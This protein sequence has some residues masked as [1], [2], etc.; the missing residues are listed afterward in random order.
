MA[1]VQSISGTRLGSAFIAK[2]LKPDSPVLMPNPTWGNHQA[3]L[4]DAGLGSDKYP[5]FNP[6]TRMLDFEGMM[7]KLTSAPKGSVVLLHVCAHNPT[8][9]DPTKE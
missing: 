7:G 2:F 3:I 1:T 9:V 6:K 8:G 5:Y 4:T